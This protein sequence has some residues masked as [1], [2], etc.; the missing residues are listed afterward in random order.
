MLKIA[1]T[2]FAIIILFFGA[3]QF[4]CSA[5]A[6]TPEIN[7]IKDIEIVEFNSQSLKLIITASVINK[8]N[9]EISLNKLN[10]NMFYEN[11]TIGFTERIERFSIAR[12][13][14]AD[15]ILY[16]ALDTEKILRLSSGNSDSLKLQLIGEAEAD[17][18]IINLPVDIDLNYS[19]NTE[20]NISKTVQNDIEQNKIISIE[21][22][23]LNSISVNESVVEIAFTID[24]PYELEI[25][26]QEYPS[27][28]FINDYK[29]GDGNLREIITLQSKGKTEGFMVYDL[30]NIKALT[31]LIGSVFKRKWEYETKGNLYLSI[32]G[33]NFKFPYSFNGELIKI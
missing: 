30:N 18:G 16:A 25:T 26:V 15:L 9:Y 29:S 22:A 5:T 2:I 20:D 21:K 13:D 4:L 17:V 6:L 23:T 32:L 14:T 11:D 1:I 31:T 24:N 28:I 3:N 19:F 7:E 10:A 12:I 27:Q 33:F 8:N